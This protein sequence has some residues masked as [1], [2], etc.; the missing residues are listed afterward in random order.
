MKPDQKMRCSSTWNKQ[1]KNPVSWMVQESP[2]SDFSS[3]AT[4]A[5]AFDIH[6]ATYFRQPGCVRPGNTDVLV[7]GY[8]FLLDNGEESLP[9]NFIKLN[10]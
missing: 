9:G 1:I 4:L 5:T 6:N 10:T 7:E 2:S 8:S 3:G